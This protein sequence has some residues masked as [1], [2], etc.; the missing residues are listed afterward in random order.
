MTE[1]N[2]GTQTVEELAKKPPDE[3]SEQTEA[4][5]RK[6]GGRKAIISAF[7]TAEIEFVKPLTWCGK[8]YEKA[9][10]NFSKLTGVDMEAIDE[11]LGNENPTFPA[12]S[13]K[14]QKLLAAKA[15][16]IPSD[17]I[18]HLAAADYHAVISAAQRFL[19]ASG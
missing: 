7:D 10:L 8:T 13:R 15:S 16:G 1:E 18:E 4:E 12:Q 6:A 14:Y 2:A 9:N 3:L 11:E 19:L 5:T 17:A